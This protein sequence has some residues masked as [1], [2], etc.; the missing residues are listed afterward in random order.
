MRRGRSLTVGSPGRARRSP[1]RRGGGR[2]ARHGERP[3]RGGKPGSAVRCRSGDRFASV[4]T[5]RRRSSRGERSGT[6]PTSRPWSTGFRAPTPLPA[7]RRVGH[8]GQGSTLYRVDN[9]P[10]VLMTGPL[11]AWRSF[12]A[13]M[14]DGPDVAQLESNLIALGDARGLFSAVSDHFSAATVGRR[15]PV[16]A[17]RPGIRPPVRSP[18]VS[19]SFFPAPSSSARTTSTWGRQ[20]R[21]ETRPLP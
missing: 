9:L 16:A 13:G 17:R 1:S 4:P 21:R 10:V 19:W 15:R 18:W 14:S 3:Q 2:D 8:R 20:L 7:A 11:P 5:W 12:S 6:P